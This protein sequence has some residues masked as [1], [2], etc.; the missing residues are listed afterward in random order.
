[1][2][3]RALPA[4]VSTAKRTGALWCDTPVPE[5]SVPL[6]T[7]V[8]TTPAA[9]AWKLVIFAVSES[10][11]VRGAAFAAGATAAPKAATDIT[12]MTSLRIVFS[13]S[14]RE[15]RLPGARRLI[16]RPRADTRRFATRGV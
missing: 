10:C 4:L 5:R 2:L 15:W 16:S 1:M 3:Q 13:F 7:P 6:N 8:A 12:A 11:E 14:G 9:V